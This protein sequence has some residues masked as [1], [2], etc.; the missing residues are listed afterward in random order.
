M[1][2]RFC[3]PPGADRGDPPFLKLDEAY[4]IDTGFACRTERDGAL[5]V[6]ASP[7]GLVG[8]GG[9]R[10]AI[11]AFQEIIADIDA[12]ATL[13]ALPD[14]LNGQRLAGCSADDEALRQTLAR[15]GVNPLVI[16]AF[17]ARRAAEPAVAEEDELR[18]AG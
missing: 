10:I 2:P 14:A 18:R 17:R 11:G 5:V 9:Y 6:T 15:R 16:G 12:D 7:P 13:A 1:T 4:F 3:Y 8:V